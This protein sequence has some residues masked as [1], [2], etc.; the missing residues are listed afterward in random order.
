MDSLGPTQEATGDPT[1]DS[2][3]L[4]DEEGGSL[5]RILVPSIILDT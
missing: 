4:M 5:G 1:K 2:L 3:H